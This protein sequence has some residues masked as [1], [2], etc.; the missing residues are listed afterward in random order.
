METQWYQCPN[1]SRVFVGSLA[2]VLALSRDHACRQIAEPHATVCMDCLIAPSGRCVRHGGIVAPPRVSWARRIAQW[3]TQRF[4]RG[5][6]PAKP[7]PAESDPIELKHEL[8]K[9]ASSC[10]AS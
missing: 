9:V 6:T 3:A 5:A 8:E 4:A 1:C 7:L 10:S 2:V